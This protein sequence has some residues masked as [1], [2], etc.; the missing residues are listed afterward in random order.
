MS[1]ENVLICYRLEI[2]F[3]GFFSLDICSGTLFI[4]LKLVAYQ[5]LKQHQQARNHYQASLEI[6]TP[7]GMP[8]ICL[9]A[10]QNYGHL[11][12]QEN[13]WS[14]AIAPYQKAIEA[15]EILLSL[16][17]ISEPTRPY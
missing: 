14:A 12:F 5:D 16:I 3:W 17:H 4:L 9:N 11:E 6:A 8:T 2:L 7:E 1:Q 13:N 15:A 10:G